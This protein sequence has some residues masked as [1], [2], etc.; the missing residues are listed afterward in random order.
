MKP[1]HAATLALVGWYLM[2]P[3]AREQPPA[4]IFDH[5]PLSQWQIGQQDAS[6]AECENSIKDFKRH[7]EN[8]SSFD[9]I[10]VERISRGR[11]MASDDPRLKD[12]EEI[13]SL[14]N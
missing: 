8:T 7:T 9:P 1:R 11:C 5:A 12:N 6:K 13:N 3:P 10:T 2:I 14:G 4:Q